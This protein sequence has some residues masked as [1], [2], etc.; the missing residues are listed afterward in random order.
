[1]DRINIITQRAYPNIL[2]RTRHW[3]TAL[4]NK[5]NRRAHLTR[6]DYSGFAS[7]MEFR[8]GGIRLYIL[9]ELCGPEV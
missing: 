4:H 2:S 6:L 5:I 9:M 7:R 1:M 8:C 3:L